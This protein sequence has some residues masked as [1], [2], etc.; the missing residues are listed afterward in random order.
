M[1][2]D[3]VQSKIMF[4]PHSL[5]STK[6]QICARG[7]DSHVGLGVAIGGATKENKKK[8]NDNALVR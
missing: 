3:A 4:W 8:D 1:S 6:S 2:S 5:L 7:M